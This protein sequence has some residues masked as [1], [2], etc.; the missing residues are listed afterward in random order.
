MDMV[1]HLTKNILL[2]LGV[3]CIIFYVGGSPSL[4]EPR[5]A[6]YTRWIVFRKIV[7]G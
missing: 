6:F 3:V 4:L 7:F 2:Y 1:L 5:I